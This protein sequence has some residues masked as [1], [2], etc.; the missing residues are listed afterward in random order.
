MDRHGGEVS[1]LLAPRENRKSGI[2]IA[3]VSEHRPNGLW[4]LTDLL[5]LAW[6][7]YKSFDLL[8]RLTLVDGKA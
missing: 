3:F 7:V 2:R 5:D 4:N 6:P 8:G 1:I